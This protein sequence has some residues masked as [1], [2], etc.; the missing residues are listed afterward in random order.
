VDAVTQVF[1]ER[2]EEIETYLELLD[3]LE[4]QVQQ[5]PPRIGAGGP[6]ITAQQQ[7][8]L[9]SSVFLQ[10][11]NLVEAT[12][13]RCLD[14][15]SAAAAENGRWQ[16]GD[17]CVELRREWVRFVA[18]THVDLN[19]EN[20]L[21]H[22]FELCEHL[23][24]MLPVADWEVARGGGGSW[25]DIGIEALGARLGFSLSISDPVKTRVK[26]HFR[27]EQGALVF[28][29][30]FRNWLAHG[31]VSFAEGGEGVTVRDL[32]ELTEGTAL[33][34]REVVACFRSYIDGYEF[35]LPERRPVGTGGG[36][37]P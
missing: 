11:Y 32:R 26:R 9:Y 18:R 24:Q 1:E 17:L 33:Y 35:L 10:L 6:V 3:N 23:V 4:K 13:T 19:Y 34:L 37:A 27:N 7:R 22:A 28:I 16:P 29:K 14:A 25:D 8:I 15:V 30:T 5:G 2:L 20:R 31:N 21:T 36:A 12:V